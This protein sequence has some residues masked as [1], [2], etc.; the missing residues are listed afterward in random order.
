MLHFC[1]KQFH[2]RIICV[3]CVTC[4]K[5]CRPRTI[6]TFC[7]AKEMKSRYCSMCFYEMHESITVYIIDVFT[8]TNTSHISDIKHSY[9][10][11][12]AKTVNGSLKRF[13]ATVCVGKN[14]LTSVELVLSYVLF[15][16]NP[17]IWQK[18]LFLMLCSLN[19][20]R[21][22]TLLN[23]QTYANAHQCFSNICSIK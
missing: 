16:Q 9:F 15:G 8:K 12:T 6:Y 2:W 4:A 21:L 13:F 19:P 22:V 17:H 18:Y 7:G 3:Y 5:K 20:E 10:L 23:W 1:W 11:C 14:N